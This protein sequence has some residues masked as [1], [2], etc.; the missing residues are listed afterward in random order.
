M[1]FQTLLVDRDE[2]F[3]TVT[4]NRPDQLNALSEQVLTELAEL[5]TTLGGAAVRGMLLTGAGERAF[6]AGADIK[7]MAQMELAQGAAFGRLGQHVT[8]AI[9]A[10]PF[11]VI[12]CVD[13]VA[14]G[15]GC[16]LAM[17]AD[18]I[19]ATK[20]ASFGQPEVKLGLIP[21]FGGCVRL[22]RLV[23]P[24]RAKELIYSGR[25]IGALEAVRMG[26]VNQVFAD[27]EGMLAGA[28][29]TLAEI[30]ERSPLA[31]KLC[32]HVFA[33]L[34]GKSTSDQLALE[35]AAFA[36]AFASEDKQVGVAAF[37]TKRVPTFVG[38]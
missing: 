3:V 22:I 13:G 23:G 28:R 25:A 26:L 37:V 20:R 1:R 27:R 31:V 32:K 6:V 11:P 36:R 2:S 35:A 9:E 24:A 5:C 29:A 16:E 14:F 34:D 12:A 17:A 4:I 7:R 19:Y 21:G 18:F 15:G 8:E 33:K 30:A 10:L 38:R